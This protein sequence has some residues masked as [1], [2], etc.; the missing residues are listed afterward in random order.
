MNKSARIAITG[1][2]GFVGKN[3]FVRL[4]EAGYVDVSALT[5]QSKSDNIQDVISSAD[6]IFHLAGANRPVHAEEFIET[7]VGFTAEIIHMMQLAQSNPPILFNSSARATDDAHGRSKRAAEDSLMAYAVQ[8]LATSDDMGD[9]YRIRM[10]NRDLN[11][12]AYFSEG[13]QGIR[14]YEEYHSHNTQQ[15]TVAETKQAL[16]L[17]AEVQADLTAWKAQQA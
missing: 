7:N 8:E 6:V 15:L 14:T 3:L 17:L 12:K 1:A 2:D 4:Q 11:Y 5:R 16:L 10:D 13:E 9:Y